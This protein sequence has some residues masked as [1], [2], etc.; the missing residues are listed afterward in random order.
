MAIGLSSSKRG[1]RYDNTTKP[2]LTFTGLDANLHRL[3]IPNE[4]YA[5]ISVNPYTWSPANRTID[6]SVKAR[7]LTKSVATLSSGI[8]RDTV[9]YNHSNYLS[10]AGVGPSY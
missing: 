4:R 3:F 2:V 10:R 9:T 1:H 5:S 6:Q 8:V 7:N